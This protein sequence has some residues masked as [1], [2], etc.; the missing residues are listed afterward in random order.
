MVNKPSCKSQ[1]KTTCGI[2]YYLWLEFRII[3]YLIK[4][5]WL[6]DS[7]VLESRV[8]TIFNQTLVSLLMISRNRF[9]TTSVQEQHTIYFFSFYTIL[10]SEI[11][12]PY[13]HDVRH[14]T[15]CHYEK[16]LILLHICYVPKAITKITSKWL[17]RKPKYY[18]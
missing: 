16:E 12:T 9:G 8:D 2:T 6:L 18:T 17:E 13:Q 5:S 7:T 4:D 1:S 14:N 11:V 3:H 10:L 15:Q